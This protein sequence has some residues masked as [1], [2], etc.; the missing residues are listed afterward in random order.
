VGRFLVARRSALVLV[1]TQYPNVILGDKVGLYPVSY[2][3]RGGRLVGVNVA[4]SS[5][6]G[7]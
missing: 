6:K 5:H 1:V 3:G 2:G 7:V 4:Y